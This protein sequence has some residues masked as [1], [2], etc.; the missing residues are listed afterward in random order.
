MISISS[1][2]SKETGEKDGAVQMGHYEPWKVGASAGNGWWVD[3][4]VA[5]GGRLAVKDSCRGIIIFE[6]PKALSLGKSL[7]MLRVALLPSIG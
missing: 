6:R 2:N 3:S 5:S 1:K 4:V 7:V